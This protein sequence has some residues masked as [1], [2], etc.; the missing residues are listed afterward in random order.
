MLGYALGLSSDQSW[1]KHKFLSVKFQLLQKTFPFANHHCQERSLV[2]KA[3]E[4]LEHEYKSRDKEAVD[5]FI[6]SS[7]IYSIPTVC[8]A[9]L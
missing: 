2:W 5:L 7:N 3:D 1:E 9:L 6:P 8:W 4:Q